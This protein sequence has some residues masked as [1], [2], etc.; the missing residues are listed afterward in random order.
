MIARS[1]VVLPW[2]LG[3]ITTA[4]LPGLDVE[5]EVADDHRAVVA[6]HEAA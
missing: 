5:V 3:P 4:V 1:S 6:G 2:P